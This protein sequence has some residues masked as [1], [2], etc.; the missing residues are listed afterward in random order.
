VV[1]ADVI[2]AFCGG[3]MC[4]SLVHK[5]GRE[6]PKTSKELLDIAT[7]HVSGEEVVG[8]AFTLAEA[9]AATGGG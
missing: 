9:G 7:R 3:T 6:Q 5:L 2:S 1:N 4:H 8:A